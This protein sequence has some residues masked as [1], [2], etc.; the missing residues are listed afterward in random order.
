MAVT[1][2]SAGSSK[3]YR[4]PPTRELQTDYD[5]IVPTNNI[6]RKPTRE[7]KEYLKQRED[8]ELTE[9]ERDYPVTIP[10]VNI[11]TDTGC[12]EESAVPWPSQLEGPLLQKIAVLRRALYLAGKDREKA[13]NG[14]K[15][16]IKS[17]RESPST[18]ASII[19]HHMTDVRR[20]EE[21]T[22]SGL[23]Q[24]A[25]NK[26]SKRA[27][28]YSRYCLH[29]VSSDP[30]QVLYGSCK[31]SDV[32]S[33]QCGQT[34]LDFLLNQPLC[35]KHVN[36]TAIESTTQ[37]QK[38]KTTASNRLTKTKAKG[39]KNK[40]SKTQSA[41]KVVF[42]KPSPA[43]STVT[44]QPITL[45]NLSSNSSWS[46]GDSDGG[47]PA[48]SAA[49]RVKISAIQPQSSKEP[50]RLPSLTPE[51]LDLSLTNIPLPSLILPP[52]LPDIGKFMDDSSSE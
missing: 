15:L 39:Q 41:T 22:V 51:S 40:K 27:V 47:N 25:D 10:S 48:I 42:V 50:D 43:I 18:T 11:P 5:A 33:T 45:P 13:E 28:L 19:S 35:S 17:A 44:V 31:S 24:C 6:H 14:V 21:R 30:D 29:H 34:V 46:S 2:S 12:R 23:V 4:F 7:L 20:Q 3:L 37:Q 38:R 52:P 36:K 49:K 26:C 8:E 16:L 32:G 1:T 9:C